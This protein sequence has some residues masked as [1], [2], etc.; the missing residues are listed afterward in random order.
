MRTRK[1]RTSKTVGRMSVL[2]WALAFGLSAG[3]CSSA[4]GQDPAPNGAS[5]GSH[6]TS[7]PTMPGR[8]TPGSFRDRPGRPNGFS[9]SRPASRD[10]QS[11]APHI[12]RTMPPAAPI[13]PTNVEPEKAK[14]AEAEARLEALRAAALAS[15]RPADA[16]DQ[17]GVPPTTPD[18]P[19][20]HRSPTPG[21]PTTGFPHSAPAG[22]RPTHG[23]PVHTASPAPTVRPGVSPVPM[24]P[25]GTH[26]VTPAGTSGS[27]S[28]IVAPPGTTSQ[29]ANVLSPK[30]Q[31]NLPPHERK[32]FFTW[33]NTPFRKTCEDL[34]E[35]T[36]LSLIGLDTVID[37]DKNKAITFESLKLTGFDDALVQYNTKICQELGM[38]YWVLE[39]DGYLEIRQLSEWYRRFQPERIYDSRKAYEA[40]KL[41][42]WEMASLIA[43][44]KHLPAHR[45][46]QIMMDNA[47]DNTFRAVVVPDTNQIRITGAVHHIDRVLE[48]ADKLDV[49]PDDPR[50][51]RSYSLKY[52]S[53]GD[54]SSLLQQMLQAEASTAVAPSAPNTPSPAP[55]GTPP[56]F[57]G[58]SPRPAAPSPAELVQSPIDEVEIQEPVNGNN[59]LIKAS[60]AKHK[61]IQELLTDFVDR[62][63]GT[64]QK[65]EI[66]Q[67]KYA[68]PAEMIETLT[69]FLGEPRVIQPQAPAPKPGQPPTPP[70]P[71]TVMQVNTKA[72]LT[73]LGPRGILIKA[74]DKEMKQIKELIGMLDI[75]REG[76]EKYQVVKLN[77]ASASAVAN[78]LQ[79]V[80]GGRVSSSSAFRRPMPG[81]PIVSSPQTQGFKA[82]PDTQTDRSLVLSGSA[83]DIEAAKA[84]IAQ[85]DVDPSAGAV[86]HLVELKNAEPSAVVQILT[87]RFGGSSSSGGGGYGYSPYGYS[88]RYRSSGG[89]DNSSLPQFIPQDDAKL[90]IV[91]CHDEMWD[92]IQKLISDLDEKFQ[93]RKTTRTYQIKHASAESLAG[94]LQE[95]LG[96]GGG[97]SRFYGSGGF[98]GRSGGGE[99][100]EP[101]FV[102][103]PTT[104]LLLVTAL[105]RDHEK[106]AD[107]IKQLDQP[108]PGDKTEYK[109]IQLNKA[110]AEYVATKIEEVLSDEG[111]SPSRRRSYS[112]YGYPSYGGGGSSEGAPK[113]P[114]RVV[115]EPIT[116]RVLVS[117]SDEDFA[118]AEALAKEIDKHFENYERKMF[119]LAHADPS[120]VQQIIQA[121]Y[122]GM[123]STGSSKRSRSSSYGY[124]SDY[125]YGG[126]SSSPTT[127]GG[128]KV[129]QIGA[130]L[131]VLAP[132]DKMAEIQ[133]VI[134]DLDVDPMAG[135][136]TKIYKVKNTDYYGTYGVAESLRQ[137]FGLPTDRSGGYRSGTSSNKST[138]KFIGEYGSD[139]LFVSA[140]KAR[141]PEID[142]GVQ[143]F[144]KAKGG[145]DMTMVIRHFTVTKA[146]PQDVADIVQP[147]LETKY[148][149]LQEQSGSSRNRYGY[150][151]YGSSSGLQVTVN[152]ITR[153]IM[154]VAPEELM[155]TAEQM[156]KD[157]DQEGVPT[158]TRI[159]ALKKA[160][161]EDIASVVQD[162]MKDSPSVTSVR[163]RSSHRRSSDYGS[164]YG[165]PGYGYGSSGSP[166]S[167]QGDEDLQVTPVE[168]SNSIILRGSEDKVADAEKLIK[169]LDDGAIPEGPMVKVFPIQFAD[170]YSVMGMIE[171]VA[172]SGGSST[173]GSGSGLT[174]KASLSSSAAVTVTPEYSMNRLIVAAPAEKF[175]LIEQI[176]DVQEQLAREK[177][178]VGT[179]EGDLFPTDNGEVRKIY[180]VEGPAK[181]IAEQLDKVMVAVFGYMDAPLVKPFPMANQIVITGKPK[182]FKKAEEYLAQIEK[183]PP[184]PTIKIVVTRPKGSAGRLV[185]EVERLAP[186][187]L[188][189]TSV[190]VRQIN[191][192]S[193]TPD[194]M[195]IFR[196]REIRID[197]PFPS[198]TSTTS[199]AARPATQPAIQ[200]VAQASPFVPTGT[201]GVLQRAL[202]A[203]PMAQVTVVSKRATTRPASASSS[204]SRP[205]VEVVHLPST[206]RPSLTIS[207]TT[208]PE[209]TRVPKSEKN[210]AAET[211]T[212]S[213]PLEGSGIRVLSRPLHPKASAA[214]HTAAAAPVQ[215]APPT[216]APTA[217]PV[218][219]RPAAPAG[220]AAA[221]ADTAAPAGAHAASP[222]EPAAGGGAAL[223]PA[224]A[225][226]NE[227][228][229]AP[230]DEQTDQAGNPLLNTIRQAGLDVLATRQ[231]Q[232]LVDEKA[233]S[234]III[235]PEDQVDDLQKLMDM[236]SEQIDKLEPA[237]KAEI[238]VF[239]LE[240]VDVTVA[241]SML[242]AMFGQPAQGKAPAQAKKPE[243]RK[244]AVGKN[245]KPGKPGEEGAEE[246]SAAGQRKREEEEAAA[247]E[248]ENAAKAAAAAQF[249]VVPDPRTRTL[250]IK[251][252]PDLFPQIAELLL[253]IDRPGPGAPVN[254]KIFQLK[255]LNAGEVEDVLKAILKIEDTRR[256]ALGAFPSS[257]RL[258]SRGMG[259]PG[260]F[261][262]DMIEAMQQ[263][264]MEMQAAAATPAAG[265][266]GENKEGTV[267]INPAKE[268]S[269][270]S[271]ATTNSVIVQAPDDGMKLVERLID[272]L[273]KQVV[274]V[275]VQTVTLQH[276]EAE[277]VATELEK[278]Y[279]TSQRRSSSSSSGR[280][281]FGFGL[282]RTGSSS[283]QSAAD[284]KV[285]ADARTN[286]LVIRALD[287]DMKNILNLVKELDV[288]P[289]IPVVSYALEQA[290]A[291]SLVQSLTAMFGQGTSGP[292]TNG[293]QTVRITADRGTNTLLVRAPQPQQLLIA[294]KIKEL[295]QLVG[296]QK[297]IRQ[298]QLEVATAADVAAKLQEIFIGKGTSA[299]AM[300][301]R[302][303]ISGDNS[304][305]TLFVKCPP[306]MFEQIKNVAMMMD[307]TIEQTVKV[308]RLKNAAAVDVLPKLKEMASQM[309]MRLGGKGSEDSVFAASAD[310]RTNSLIVAGTPKAILAV[311]TVLDAVDVPPSDKT[312]VTTKMFSLLRG[313][314]TTV[315]AT[316]NNLY[317]GKRW[318]G[319]GV[320][321]PRAA[322]D[323]SANVVF[324]TG[325]N[326]QLDL[327][328]TQVVDP[329]EGL[330]PPSPTSVPVQE[331][332]LKLQFADADEIAAKIKDLFTQQVAARKAAGDTSMT[333]LDQAIAIV[334]EPIGRRLFVSCSNT[335]MQQVD[336][337]VKALDVPEASDSGQQAE[338]IP[339]KFADLTYTV[340]ALNSTFK[341][342]GKIAPG[343]QVTISPEYG[344]NSIVVKAPKKDMEAIKKLL[345]E[346]DKSDSGRLVPPVTIPVKHLR[347][348]Q[349]ASQLT[350][351]IARNF[352]IDKQTSQ[353]PVSVSG[354]DTGNVLL[355]TAQTQANMD[356]ILGLITQLDT[357]PAEDERLTKSYV[358]QFADLT[359]TQTMITKRFGKQDNLP[360]HEQLEISAD[361]TTG[362][363]IVTASEANHKKVE[364]IVQEVD[365]SDRDRMRTPETIK[366]KN[367]RAS[368]LAK[369]LNEMI[370]VY[371][372]PEKQTG[373]LPIT[374]TA[375][376]TANTL[377]VTARKAD[378]EDMRKLIEQLDVPVKVSDARA[379]KQYTLKFAD[380]AVVKTAITDS[381]P[382]QEQR[383]VNDQ[384]A[385]TADYTSSS[386]LVTASGENQSRVQ[387]IVT[388]LDTAG[389]GTRRTF[390]MDLK[391]ADPEDLA[392]TLTTIYS[393]AKPRTRTGQAPA[394]FTAIPGT[395]TLA[396]TCTETEFK[397]AKALV[398]QLDLTVS[399]A[400]AGVDKRSM[401]VVSVK[402]VAPREMAQ[403]LTDYM[404]KPGKSGSRDTTLVDDV[405]ITASDS[406]DA[407]VLTGP[408][409]RLDELEQ[410]IHKVDDAAPPELAAGG[411]EMAVIALTNA[412]PSSVAQVISQT[413]QARG[414]VPE[415]EKVSAV[416]E[417]ATNSIVVTATKD[418]LDQIRKMVSDLDQESENVPQQSIIHLKHARSEDL[419]TVLTQTYRTS[420]RGASGP[421]I[422]FASDSNS[423]ALVISAGKAD[424]EGIQK[425]VE[426]LDKPATDNVQEL[427]VIPLQYIDAQET[428]QIMSEYLRKPS[429]AAG[430][431]GSSGSDL[432]GDIRLQ[433]SPTLN[434]LVA[435][436]SKEELDRVEQ[437]VLAM[438]QEVQGA[439]EPKVIKVMNTTATSLAATLTKIFTDP[440]QR[441]AGSRTSQDTIPLIMA[442]EAT[443][444]VVVR[445][446]SMDYNLIEKMIRQLDQETQGST[447]IKVITV[448]RGVDVT[449][450][451]RQIEQTVNRGEQLKTRTVKGYVPKEIAVGSDDRASALIVAGAPEM[452]PTV[453]KLANELDKKRDN[454]GGRRA[455]VLPVRTKS[456]QDIQKVLEQFIEQ[457]NGKKR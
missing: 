372:K 168:S 258:G 427:R 326:A 446:R 89:G 403:M 394:V 38:G 245:A 207:S 79:T 444:S 433:A 337:W 146:R 385:V 357:R 71:P 203:V 28:G 311:Q 434:A 406:A 426:D 160:K 290:D 45:W 437:R 159:L 243:A 429:A 420:R 404:R 375:N 409:G 327:I 254:I 319:V 305:K 308:I 389:G 185:T 317:Q 154:V 98:G 396:V 171:D 40:A 417:Q 280:S 20:L 383:P 202:A 77:H 315:A 225:G 352:R 302:L 30:Q 435:S 86:E 99:S 165:Y 398:D 140:P 346:I 177:A 90:L 175:P 402:H 87:T 240:N 42:G 256:G 445:A 5:P 295:D 228:A 235:G 32:Y 442:D 133:K 418:K 340:N 341:K 93:T 234:V 36:G 49:P 261:D 96:G 169:T 425:M 286:K 313:N 184:P 229:P 152:K 110:D 21:S 227:A 8:P 163:S 117:A 135:T 329:L 85:L 432:I 334:P 161:A 74:D 325:T 17:P 210:G 345:A 244:P 413:F 39:R 411:R 400:E 312:Q 439:G 12:E 238:R 307:K 397:E 16:P 153:K 314:S 328:K 452:F 353:Y 139:V 306:E 428:L 198:N 252:S 187:G 239:P 209:M 441:K 105:E 424:L 349:L 333:A 304:S 268:I 156:I 130:G 408:V 44:P 301:Q 189:G 176:I 285:T 453:E 336:R 137:L 217:I 438:D 220:A 293:A 7:R 138:V 242:D 144:L 114:V 298:I 456:A 318:V 224:D 421:P 284:F 80:I 216:Q 118:K 449:N 422:S 412:Y 107:L 316:I 377:L 359:S 454:L 273:E 75:Q 122:E 57:R 451:A 67:L 287:A 431:R 112:P 388:T 18:G 391:N 253:K 84:L 343:E 378:M 450:L 392:Q 257:R 13:P 355:V 342:T 155:A 145:A 183:N 231:P 401:R 208:R 101:S 43:V 14:A 125:P 31:W 191:T 255:K 371:K 230:A 370:R 283:G 215:T 221:A 263:Q 136:E 338:V 151:P 157:F 97:R 365:V 91:L 115:A 362:A 250:I 281:G 22:V 70:P 448:S 53:P 214:G 246:D 59:L 113:V 358:L 102:V 58:R 129:A 274:P 119:T 127:A 354:E 233:N 270:T 236:I 344:T 134:N 271:E 367:V 47:L 9:T 52:L 201:V 447:D 339:V 11:G 264:V 162:Q 178:A 320:E 399:G 141:M 19:P 63:P 106:A 204:T 292:T 182:Y 34:V 3:W 186:R 108:G 148:R 172:G 142:R 78:V 347:A 94:V 126:S 124:G 363:L 24:P 196:R 241:A 296:G 218:P 335:S 303:S 356:R 33:N 193:G 299:R 27:P 331:H 237:G 197:T 111:S 374:V 123:S 332:E 376:D 143:E 386:V 310:E 167:S 48:I 414:N 373:T 384:V 423:N 348:T 219:A 247:K 275:S 194:A 88:S 262:V 61:R 265:A 158:V 131:I 4:L 419:V 351:M 222:A 455:L 272:D 212:N 200:P 288:D 60:P 82:V 164:P 173:Y 1:T 95:A 291:E 276:A 2:L 430:R 330:Q 205:A 72:K 248:A 251:A 309:I 116:N 206:T 23:M 41:P 55:P 35:L 66:V 26:G 300:Q 25:G 6:A 443:N 15:T 366:V 267:K 92:D 73:P 64:T 249:K 390:T 278:I 368:E 199:P 323:P 416:A 120:E 289:A 10:P 322:A 277:K 83:A 192:S 361:P 147:I 174:K 410:L 407:V 297:E 180:P 104:N 132:K 29:P 226:E 51:W 195:E 395:R 364:A 282:D 190:N 149:E 223:L 269:I 103:N 150:S 121:M 380:P 436:G 37:A 415:S 109:P 321:A 62:E 294:A 259:G 100:T 387:E 369:T 69:P 211:P 76:D 381:F 50:E 179:K 382:G 56:G 360:Q 457:Q 379:M 166:S 279:Q 324:V 440:A 405:K 81:Q 65:L 266:G 260:G 350:T 188:G 393:N 54:A 170:L 232:I 128:V 46:A 213:L 181:E 68:D